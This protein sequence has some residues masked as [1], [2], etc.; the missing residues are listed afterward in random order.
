MNFENLFLH[1]R[2]GEI[3]EHLVNEYKYLTEQH[4]LKLKAYKKL[5]IAPSPILHWSNLKI[6]HWQ[7]GNLN[8]YVK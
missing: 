1:I 7:P 6:I 2:F 8:R 5:H 3:P 4:I